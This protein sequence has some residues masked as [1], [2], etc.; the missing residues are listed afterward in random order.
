MNWEDYEKGVDGQLD[1][2]FM[3]RMPTDAERV[4]LAL[5]RE[6]NASF[7]PQPESASVGSNHDELALACLLLSAQWGKEFTRVTKDQ[8]YANIAVPPYGDEISKLPWRLCQAATLMRPSQAE[9]VRHLTAVVANSGRHARR[10]YMAMAWMARPLLDVRPMIWRL[11]DLFVAGRTGSDQA[12]GLARGLCKDQIDW[13]SWVA[14]YCQKDGSTVL[15]D[16]LALLPPG[17]IAAGQ[18]GFK[19]LEAR[20]FKRVASGALPG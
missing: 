17:A 14:D 5:A 3:M 19:D 20:C 10:R 11:F 6:W 1:F 16:K 4:V 18:Q 7:I 12:L 8:I 15:R 2:P 13:D 9:A